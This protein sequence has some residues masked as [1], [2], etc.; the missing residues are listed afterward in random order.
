MKERIALFHL[1][2][3]GDVVDEAVVAVG[4]KKKHPD[5]FLTA[6]I[7]RARYAPILQNVYDGGR[8]VVDLVISSPVVERRWRGCPRCNKVIAKGDRCPECGSKVKERRW[9]D[10]LDWQEFADRE[11]K[12]GCYDLFYE[13]LP[14]VGRIWKGGDLLTRRKPVLLPPAGEIAPYLPEKGGYRGFLSV[15]T[16]RQKELG[17]N[18]IELACR[19]MDLE[20]SY[21]KVFL[22]IPREDRLSAEMKV[23]RIMRKSP[24]DEFVVMTNGAYLSRKGDGFNTKKWSEARFG[25]VAAW[26]KDHLGLEVIHLGVKGEKKIPNTRPLL[27]K[28]NLMEAAWILRAARFVVG[29]EGGLVR[30]AA[31]VGTRSVVLFGPTPVE[32]YNIPGNIPVYTGS[33]DPCFW[34]T[35]DWMVRCPRGWEFVEG[36]V[37]LA[38]CMYTISVDMVIDAIKKELV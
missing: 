30:L 23:E 5:S 26:I 19:S 10:Y 34:L 17:L 18:V 31:L 28:T 15:K 11:L 35:G 3:L 6:C 16:N 20:C 38:K 37:K 8:K 9:K 32:M 25:E 24:F 13:W 7:S 12:E 2:S 4:V 21:D 22:K 33:C 1:G 29:D 14:Y 36:K 27:G